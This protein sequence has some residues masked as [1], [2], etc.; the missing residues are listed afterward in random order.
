MPHVPGKLF[1]PLVV[2]PPP[3]RERP[4]GRGK[5][6]SHRDEQRQIY[7]IIWS[8]AKTN[9]NAFAGSDYFRRNQRMH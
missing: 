8:P 2:L 6:I 3:S 7:L 9:K 5:Q 1:G 4:G